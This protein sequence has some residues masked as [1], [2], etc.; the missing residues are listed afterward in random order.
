MNLKVAEQYI[1]NINFRIMMVIFLHKHKETLL[2]VMH[3]VLF[4]E[5]VL[6]LTTFI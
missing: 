2:I 3:F 1:Q 5:R 4:F 6:L